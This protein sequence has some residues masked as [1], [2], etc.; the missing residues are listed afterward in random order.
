[1]F[2]VYILQSMKDDSLYKGVTENLLQRLH[3]HNTGSAKYSSSKRPYKLLW[4]CAFHDKIKALQFEKYLKH[5]SGHEFTKKH[6]L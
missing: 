6:F 4:Y 5:G 2:Y 1:M 3:D